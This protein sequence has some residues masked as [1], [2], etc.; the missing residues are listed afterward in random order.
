MPKR[1]ASNSMLRQGYAA[2]SSVSLE[3]GV[4]TSKSTSLSIQCSLANWEGAADSGSRLGHLAAHP[5]HQGRQHLW[6]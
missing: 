5:S 6:P 3:P 2:L 4:A 1:I